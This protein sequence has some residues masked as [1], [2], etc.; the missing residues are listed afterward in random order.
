M[1]TIHKGMEHCEH[2]SVAVNG[3]DTAWI[4]CDVMV[5]DCFWIIRNGKCPMRIY[6]AIS[7]PRIADICNMLEKDET[8]RWEELGR[9]KNDG[10]INGSHSGYCHA[11]R[12]VRRWLEDIEFANRACEK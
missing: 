10:Y 2:A 6:N 12:D 11:M 8:R 4:K 3:D 9:P 1:T 5:G 7:H